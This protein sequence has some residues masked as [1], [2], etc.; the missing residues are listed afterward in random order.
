MRDRQ[1]QM[2]RRKKEDKN[3]VAKE[4]EYMARLITKQRIE[5]VGETKEKHR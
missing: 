3:G 2:K 1:S 4:D 5:L